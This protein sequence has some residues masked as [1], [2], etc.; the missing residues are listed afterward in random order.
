MT[1]KIILPDRDF[2]H[3]AVLRSAQ[4]ISARAQVSPGELKRRLY[5]TCGVFAASLLV[6]VATLLAIWADWFATPAAQRLAVFL[7]VGSSGIACLSVVAT[8]TVLWSSLLY[9][10]VQRV[11]AESELLAPTAVAQ[12]SFAVWYD[13]NFAEQVAAT[14]MLHA[15][16]RL[17]MD[18]ETARKLAVN[19]VLQKDV[20]KQMADLF[21]A[22]VAAGTGQDELVRELHA[23]AAGR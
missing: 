12:E 3:A 20:Q 8:V 15:A 6:V 14:I 16:G 11:S 19:M 10:H 22:R 2:A 5:T 13:P 23:C 1:P 17:P 18:Q 21:Q 4:R 7:L 9:E